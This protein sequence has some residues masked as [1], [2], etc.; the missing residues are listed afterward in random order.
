MFFMVWFLLRF[1]N[2]TYLLFKF[3]CRERLKGS[4]GVF[5]PTTDNPF[6]SGD[7]QT[8]VLSSL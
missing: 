7:N 3:V 8:M 5:N 2:E 1:F 4:R 6:D